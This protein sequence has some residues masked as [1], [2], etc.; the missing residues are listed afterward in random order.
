MLNPRHIRSCFALAAAAAAWLGAA[1]AS[2]FDLDLRIGA[3]G[4]FSL[5][6]ISDAD[7]PPVPQA[8]W[9]DGRIGAGGGGGL[10][11]ELH[12]S[13]LTGV[14]LDLLFESNR[15]FFRG[16]QNMVAFDQRVSFEQ[17]RVP[18]LGKLFAHVSD[19]VELSA[20]LGPQ[21]ILGL[22]AHPETTLSRNGTT[23]S[24]QNLQRAFDYFY[25]A[26]A[27]SSVALAGELGLSIYTQRFQIPIALRFAYNVLGKTAYADRVK[28][29]PMLGTA[30]WSALETYQLGIVVGFGFLIP[31]RQPPPEP[32]K[33]ARPADDPFSPF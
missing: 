25:Q 7:E 12:L 24:P 30:T 3:K 17:M 27:G 32:S 20:A 15:L 5:A 19:D 21:L 26:E 8:P 11:G 14:E 16:A 31:P 10:Y 4:I 9:A 29:D 2:A 33:P 18:L 22:G 6:N 23:L 28:Q 13:K 1:P